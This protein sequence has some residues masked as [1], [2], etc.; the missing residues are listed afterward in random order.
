[1]KIYTDNNLNHNFTISYVTKRH[2]EYG[3]PTGDLYSKKDSLT[4]RTIIR[5][6]QYDS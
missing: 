5:P 2:F 6:V 1:M 3:L 4:M